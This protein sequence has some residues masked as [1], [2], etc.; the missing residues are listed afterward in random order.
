LNRL[1]VPLLFFLLIPGMRAQAPSPASIRG[2]LVR[3]GTAEPVASATIELR[4]ADRGTSPLAITASHGNG[5]FVFSNV[6]PGTYRVTAFANGYAATEY[7]QLRPS[8]GG[9]PLTLTGGQYANIR[10]GMVPSGTISGRITDQDGRPMVYASVRALRVAYDLEGQATTTMALETITNDLGEYRAFGLQPGWYVVSSGRSRLDLF[11]NQGIIDPNRSDT[12]M[13]TTM[14]NS[15]P[16]PRAS[17][18]PSGGATPESRLSLVSALYYPAAPDLSSA[19]VINLTA[20]GEVPNIDIRFSPAV[21]P[22]NG[23]SLRGVVIDPSGAPVQGPFSI[24]I[25]T[26]PIAAPSTP[27]AFVQ[28][29]TARVPST[30]P[31][32]AAR[33]AQIYV[34]DNARFE[35][36]AVRGVYQIRATQGDL[37]G[38][39]VVE[40]ENRDLDLTIPLARPASISGRVTGVADLKG[41][42]VTLRTAPNIQFTS[43]VG[44]DGEFQIKGVI[45]GD[46]QVYVPPLLPAPGTQFAGAAPAMPD[47]LRHAYVQSIRAANTDLVR[48]LLRVEGDRQPAFVEIVLSGAAPFLTGRVRN[49]RGEAVSE[50][51]V[52]VLP[53][54]KPPFRPDRYAVARTA[55][56]GEFEITGM[57]P[58]EYRLLAWEDVDPGAWFNPAFLASHERD[59]TAIRLTDGLRREVEIRAIPAARQ[60][61]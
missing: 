53:P 13:P 43:P 39:V 9:T 19:E 52:V 51:T 57:Q 29:M 15:P 61:N 3:W 31:A 41:L 10:M 38:R 37:S 50:A 12:S 47:A 27:F 33:G 35:G 23:V 16:R 45:P 30:D 26:W 7:G 59:A 20:G 54:G 18:P 55:A 24:A 2:P 46:Y 21:L 4:G 60:N 25:T 58:G 1:A 17:A 42:L 14:V 8:G 48:E 44:L 6:P 34:A 22:S 49:E 32:Q 5:D 36:G 40:V 11:G 56:S 28:M